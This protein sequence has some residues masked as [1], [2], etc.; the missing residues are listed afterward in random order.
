MENYTEIRNAQNSL[1]QHIFSIKIR[2][3]QYI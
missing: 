1:K 3:N 2:S